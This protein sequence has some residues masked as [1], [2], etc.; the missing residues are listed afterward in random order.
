VIRKYVSFHSLRK[1]MKRVDDHEEEPEEEM[2]SKQA[3]DVSEMT[4]EET[5]A[6]HMVGEPKKHFFWF[7]S[8]SASQE[9]SRAIKGQSRMVAWC[10]RFI[11]LLLFP[12]SSPEKVHLDDV[13]KL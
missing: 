13:N 4:E 2:R 11:K 9:R 6:R 7:Q 3:S 8:L 10:R 1:R 12:L 5:L